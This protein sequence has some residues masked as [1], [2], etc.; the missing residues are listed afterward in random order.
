MIIE[1]FLQ[2]EMKNHNY[3]LNFKNYKKKLDNYRSNYLKFHYK[4]F[5]IDT[6]SNKKID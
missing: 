5:Y 4:N 2:E 3:G 6:F 1:L